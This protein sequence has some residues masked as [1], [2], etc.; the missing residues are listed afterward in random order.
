MTH[1][2][3]FTASAKCHGEI[4]SEMVFRTAGYP[5]DGFFVTSWPV[6]TQWGSILSSQQNYMFYLFE[7]ILPHWKR[8]KSGSHDQFILKESIIYERL[9]KM[10]ST[11]LHCTSF[12]KSSNY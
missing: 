12:D 4:D 3:T 2:F 6:T 5:N 10:D 8:Q 11:V 7:N 9:S 1:T